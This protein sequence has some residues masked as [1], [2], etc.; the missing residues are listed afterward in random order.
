MEDHAS[1]V[2]GL[3]DALDLARV[4]VAGHSAD[5]YLAAIRSA[6]YLLGAWDDDVESGIRAGIVDNP[7]GTVRASTDASAIAQA[8][9]G[10]ACELWLHIV[11]HP[12]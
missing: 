8:A 3:L 6:S 1:D 4:V 11:Q 12:S 10:L 5:A 9:T 7:D 2:I